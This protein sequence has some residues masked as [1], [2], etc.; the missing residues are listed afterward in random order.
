[1]DKK[2]TL[3]MAVVLLV[4]MI[5]CSICAIAQTPSRLQFYDRSYDYGIGNDSIKLYFN[6]YGTDQKR[7]SNLSEE[8]FNQFFVIEEDGKAIDNFSVRRI[9]SGVRIPKDYTF[10]ILLDQ[11]IPA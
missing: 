7:V 10:S 6:L 9:S 2:K 3:N 8:N 11:S 5:L 4:W 1:M